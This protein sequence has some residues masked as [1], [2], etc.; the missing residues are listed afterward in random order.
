M[1]ED[2]E[3]TSKS[4]LS[5]R[6]ILYIFDL[7][8]RDNVLLIINYVLKSCSSRFSV[9]CRQLYRKWRPPPPHTKIIPPAFDL[10][11]QQSRWD[12]LSMWERLNGNGSWWESENGSYIYL[13]RGDGKWWMDSGETGLGLY[14]RKSR[15]GEETTTAPPTD[16][17]EQLSGAALPLPSVLPVQ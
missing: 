3:N 9:W 2:S 13:N 10:V 1:F 11:C 17:W 15:G 12:T 5:I 7:F 4:H 6:C 14:V 16:G 8:A